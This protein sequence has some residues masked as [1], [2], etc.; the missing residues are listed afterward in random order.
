VMPTCLEGLAAIAGTR[1]A[2]DRAARLFG[3]AEAIREA[4][5]APLFSP[6][7]PW[8]DRDVT[9]VRAQLD[10]A[11]FAAAWAEGRAMPFDE[12]IA[13][14]LSEADAGT[15]A[16]PTEAGPSG[17]QT[18]LSARERE[19]VGLLRQGLTNRQIAGELVVATST[20]DRHVVNILR[21]LDLA[22]R[23]QVAV[24]AVEHGL[25]AAAD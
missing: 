7:R 19:V 25:A 20:V 24:W 3:A 10:P 18:P 15:T 23:A 14:A 2:A 1:R 21:K 13:Y 11:V 6:N 8:L 22:G 16:T 5:G 9:A 12:A 17:E 4:L